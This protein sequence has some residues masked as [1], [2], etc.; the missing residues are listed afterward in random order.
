MSK[1]YFNRSGGSWL[2]QSKDRRKHRWLDFSADSK[3]PAFGIGWIKNRFILLGLWICVIGL[4]FASIIQFGLLLKEYDTHFG[5]ESTAKHLIKGDIQEYDLGPQSLLF[6]LADLRE[7]YLR[8]ATK[9]KPLSEVSNLRIQVINQFARFDA[10]IKTSTQFQNP[11]FAPA[12]KVITQFFIVLK[13][14]EDG[15]ATIDHVLST[16]DEATKVWSQFVSESTQADTLLRT[17]LT[18][19]FDHFEKATLQLLIVL[20][21]LGVLTVFAWIA[22]IALNRHNV[23]R[24]RKRFSAF[25]TVIASIG[26]D[27]GNPLGAIQEATLKLSEELTS[28]ERKHFYTLA[29]KATHSLDRLVTDI[30][31]VTH[32]EP[33]P[34]ELQNVNI[35]N[36]FADFI[37]RYA[38]KV[39][40][41]RLK[42][43]ASI[44]TH[45]MLLSLDPD[46]LNQCI[47][48]LMDNALRYTNSGEIEL[49]LSVR[50]QA[51]GSKLKALVIKVR[52]TGVGV[53]P[54]DLNRIFQPFER[55]H[56]AESIKGMGLG[57]SIVRNIANRSGGTVEVQSKVGQGSTFT[58]LIP[59]E[60]VAYIS[61]PWEESSLEPDTFIT[62]GAEVLVVGDDA[63]ETAAVLDDAGY[64][65]NTSVDSK[66]ARHL[67][68]SL[69]YQVVVVSMEMPH[70]A[71]GLGLAS[72][73]K[74]RPGSPYT[75]A[76]STAADQL[77]MESSAGSFD[78]ILMKPVTV[79]ALMQ[80]META[81]GQRD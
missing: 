26:H 76:I 8:H 38:P 58:F 36:W 56:H 35:E 50:D 67:M 45:P 53:A 24:E 2:N 19:E 15:N 9:G 47:G 49:T 61:V 71:A 42:F 46:R 70:F 64:S 44:D 41:K 31:Q 1:P 27:F 18:N 69:T 68:S 22:L 33:L 25:E 4:F 21:G 30:L 52:D 28:N 7:S 29:H 78:E 5:K 48:N 10:A 62:L 74:K 60:E 51:R 14:Y 75:I 77:R 17:V 73:C 63:K 3:R 65:V 39:E 6:S 80:A 16:G 55:A 37:G 81:L 12:F 59:V 57:L 13:N 11:S 72:E 23:L 34:V 32:G 66:T 54:E 20:G 40:K 79:S 43:K